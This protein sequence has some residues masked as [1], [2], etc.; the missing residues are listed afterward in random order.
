MHDYRINGLSQGHSLRYSEGLGSA[1][2][3]LHLPGHPEGASAAIVL[4]PEVHP[5]STT[6]NHCTDDTNPDEITSIQSPDCYS[7]FRV[8]RFRASETCLGRP[9]L[10]ELQFQP[11]SRSEPIFMSILR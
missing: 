11:F 4:R 3:I 5:L 10:L 7:N 8:Q 9:N 6:L 2:P 1:Q